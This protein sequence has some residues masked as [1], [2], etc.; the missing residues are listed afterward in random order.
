MQ[1]RWVPVD[2]IF[3]CGN[4]TADNSTHGVPLI[5]VAP[6]IT[7]IRA[8]LDGKTIPQIYHEFEKSRHSDSNYDEG[9]GAR[10][11]KSKISG[12]ASKFR[13]N[14]PL[15]EQL[16]ND[17]LLVTEGLLEA[18]YAKVK[19]QEWIK[20]EMPNSVAEKWDKRS[21]DKL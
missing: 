2:L 17:R 13:R 21:D 1:K 9:D 19:Q 14:L 12:P 11:L 15:V 8:V 3:D 6:Y 10:R 18:C 4:S 5:L 7:A 20:V 16:D